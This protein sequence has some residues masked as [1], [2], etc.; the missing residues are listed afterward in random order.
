[1]TWNR[2][3]VCVTHTRALLRLSTFWPFGGLLVD[4]TSTGLEQNQRG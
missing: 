3:F 2:M 1:M 4:L